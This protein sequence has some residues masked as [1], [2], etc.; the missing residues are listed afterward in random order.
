[1]SRSGK[2]AVFS[3]DEGDN[4]KMALHQVKLGQAWFK[5]LLNSEKLP[6]ETPTAKPPLSNGYYLSSKIGE[7]A[8]RG[9]GYEVSVRRRRAGHSQYNISHGLRFTTA[10]GS[11]G[12]SGGSWVSG[13]LAEITKALDAIKRGQEY[14]H[15]SDRYSVKANL[16]TKEAD[17]T[18]NLGAF[19]KDKT[20]KKGHFGVEQLN[21]I[22]TLIK[23]YDAKKNWFEEHEHWF[24]T[25]PKK[26]E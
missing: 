13:L 2:N 20:P 21:E 4:L 10:H 22:R 7:V 3:A 19:F 5:L 16:R 23:S 12:S 24:Y 25:K 15:K 6:K 11:M 1:M 18:L 14:R 9:I 17:V 8:G 26:G